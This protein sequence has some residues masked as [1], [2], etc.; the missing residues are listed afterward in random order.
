MI[1]R[2]IFI[3]LVLIL[4]SGYIYSNN[5]QELEITKVMEVHD[6]DTFTTEE[7]LKVRLIGINTRELGEP[8]SFDA[9]EKT[10]QLL[11]YKKVILKKDI[12]DH[13]QFGRNLR[14]VYL[15]D[16]TFINELL[17]RE[18][19]AEA[20]EYFPNIKYSIKFERLENEAKNK[21]LGMWNS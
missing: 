8:Y 13:D 12:K 3:S 18:G 2:I 7:G 20:K 19:H 9:K 16:G 5:Y 21:E 1:P 4:L 14:Y 11:L 10:T 17:V 6:G 15:E